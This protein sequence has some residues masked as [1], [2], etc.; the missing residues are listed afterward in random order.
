MF[1]ILSKILHSPVFQSNLVNFVIMVFI[2][3]KLAAPFIKKAL[4]QSA[5]NTKNTVET[6]DLNRKQ[7]EENRDTAKEKYEQTPQ[8][9]DYITRTANNTLT[10]LEKKAEEDT[11]K[12]KALLSENADKSV[13]SEGTRIKTSLTEAVAKKS[14]LTA[15]E[16]I[17][18]KLKEDENLHDLLIEQAIDEL[19]LSR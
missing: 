11:E 18:N 2:L 5:E 13:I 4:E 9:I 6:S 3:Y 17:I 14:L 7:A 12:V 15:K 16:N 1:D 19:E 10:S 8:E